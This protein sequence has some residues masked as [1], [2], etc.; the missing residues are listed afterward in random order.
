LRKIAKLIALF[1]GS[2][3]VLAG[4]GMGLYCVLCPTPFGLI[5]AKSGM[6]IR[7][8]MLTVGLIPQV[9]LGS[10]L[11][12]FGLSSRSRS[13]T[14]RAARKTVKTIIEN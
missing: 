14:Y 2:Q 11:I 8:L 1:Y 3:M 6:D 10:L 7:I 4:I 9:G 5:G 13:R 12:W